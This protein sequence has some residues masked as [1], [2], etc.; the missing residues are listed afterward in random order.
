MRA[1]AVGIRSANE[2]LALVPTMGALHRGHIEL[3]RRARAVADR[4]VVSIFVNPTQFAPGEDLEKYPRNLQADIEVCKAEGVDTLFTPAVA[5]LYPDGF[6]TTIDVGEI[7]TKLCGLSRPGHFNAVATI[8]LK[9]FNISRPTVAFFGK[10]DFQQLSIIERMASDLN[11][12]IE[13]IGVETVREADGLAMS[14][15]NRYLGTAER[16]AAVAVP[17]ALNAA[18]RLFKKGVRS[19]GSIISSVSE[20]LSRESLIEVEYIK[21]ICVK[22]LEEVEFIDEKTVLALAV[23]ISGTRLIDNLEL[24]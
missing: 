10:K 19:S 11:L 18:S 2:S 1:E 16:K 24:C 9:L 6:G 13:I 17:S 8:V 5:G 15:R 21:I 4:V 22:R 23:K 20:L 7:G 14:S 12:C 3:I